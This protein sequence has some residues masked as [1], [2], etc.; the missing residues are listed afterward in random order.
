MLFDGWCQVQIILGSTHIVQQL[1]FSM[2]LSIL[3]FEIAFSFWPRQFS[4]TVFRFNHKA[5]KLLFSVLPSI[6]TLVLPNSRVVLVWCPNVKNPR[7]KTYHS[8]QLYIFNS[9]IK[10]LLLSFPKILRAGTK[11]NADYTLF[12]QEP[13]WKA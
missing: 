4:N 8:I 2:F 10:I 9:W 7:E 12:I 5:E 11:L 1:L 6:I 3:T 13:V